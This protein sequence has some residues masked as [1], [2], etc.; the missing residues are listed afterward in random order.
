M[1]REVFVYVE[2]SEGFECRGTD[3]EELVAMPNQKPEEGSI[4]DSEFWGFM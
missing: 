2:D 1:L 4:T 3:N